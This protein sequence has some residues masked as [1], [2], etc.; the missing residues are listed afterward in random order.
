M[1]IQ[2]ASAAKKV[3]PWLGIGLLLL[4]ALWLRGRYVWV[5]PLSYDEGHWLMFG[6]LTNKGYTAYAETFVGIPPLAL[7][8]IQLGDKL[9][10]NTL[11]VRYPM[12]SVSLLGIAGIF[13][14]FRPWKNR[15]HFLIGFLAAFFLAFDTDYF[16]GSGSIMAEVPAVSLAIISFVLAQQY[17]IS[18]KWF[19]LLLSGMAFGLSIAYKI[20][21][22]FIPALIGLIIVLTLL[23]DRQES[24]LKIIWQIIMNGAIWLVGALLPWT[25]FVV[26]Y[27]P[28][29]MFKEILLFRL[30]FREVSAGESVLF[31][32]IATL[33][34]MLT[35]RIPLL[36][37]GGVGILMG[38]KKYRIFIWTW[39]AWFALTLFP[40]VWQSPLRLRYSVMLVP[41]LAALSAIAVVEVGLWLMC[42]LQQKNISHLVPQTVLAMGLLGIMVG[43]LVTPVQSAYMPASNDMYPDL[44]LDAVQYVWQNTTPDDCVVTDDQR[45]AFATDRLVPPA[46]SETAIGRLAIGWLTADDIAQQIVLHDC[47]AVVFADWRFSKYLPDLHQRLEELYFLRIPFDQD[48]VVF[49][50]NRV[51]TRQPS[52]PAQVQF[53]DAIVLEGLDLAPREWIP[54]QEVRL[55]TYW[56]AIK[57]PEQAYKIFLQIRNSDDEVILTIDHFPFPVP[58]G[59]YQ[60]VPSIDNY[61]SY[62]AEDIAA[63][64]TKG[65]LPTNAWPINN[66]IREVIAITLPPTLLADTYNVY[67]G[68]YDP[69]T[70]VR[71]PLNGKDD[72]YLLISAEVE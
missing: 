19:W 20:F 69:D 40:L 53:G 14:S 58:D 57:Q 44:N 10:H 46:L 45:F 56:T 36:L 50:A 35:D 43:Y 30:A 23:T 26:M 22:V 29:A 8:A 33:N 66:T 24:W 2:L 59:N 70:L 67:I 68:L 54:G 63:Y 65:M 15:S 42:R 28:Q 3:W 32:N 13:F 1:I 61:Q 49:T 12:M 5:N 6:V 7:L 48:M 16:M 60:P 39:V 17:S 27:N 21:M 37:G 31:Q 4:I 18:R 71:L 34:R 11:G 51:V 41:P 38:W 72:E 62:S 55:A 64:P 47:P 52:I 25:I 9:F